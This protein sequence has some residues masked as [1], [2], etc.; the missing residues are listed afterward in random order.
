MFEL[1]AIFALLILFILTVANLVEVKANFRVLHANDLHTAQVLER[2]STAVKDIIAAMRE[3]IDALGDRLENQTTVVLE[4][5]G[6]RVKRMEEE[7]E[8][9]KEIRTWAKA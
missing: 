9:V 1:F 7:H 2:Y 4:E 3:D 8:K 6:E 5:M